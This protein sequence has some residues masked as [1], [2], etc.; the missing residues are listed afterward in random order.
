MKVTKKLALIGAGYAL[1]VVGG[2]A[3]VALNELRITEDIK[4]TSGGMVA[5]GD[6]IVFVL[7]AGF[8]SLAPTWFLLKLCAEKAMRTLLAAELL[9]AATG[10]V[11]WLA[12]RWMAADPSPQSLPQAISGELGVLI[13]FGAI[14]RIVFG[15]VLLMIELATFF[16]LRERL[17]RTLL[18]LAMLMDIIPLGMFALHMAAATR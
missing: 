8:F 13:A 14:P 12:V 6:M 3:A 10:P 17:T 5:F 4:Q 15:P 16:L 1:S 7:A 2:I 18:A 9:I 11:S